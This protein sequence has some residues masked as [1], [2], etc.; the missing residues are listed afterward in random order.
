MVAFL[1]NIQTVQNNKCQFQDGNMLKSH[2]GLLFRFDQSKTADEGVIVIMHNSLLVAISGYFSEKKPHLYKH[3]SKTTKLS[4]TLGWKS[5]QSKYRVYNT[6]QL[7]TAKD[8]F[9]RLL[10]Y[11]GC[12]CADRLKG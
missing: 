7:L 11:A 10:L 4:R 2:Q 8:V 6:S 3:H 9:C 1:F 5:N 12:C